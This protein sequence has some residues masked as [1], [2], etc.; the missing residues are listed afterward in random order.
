VALCADDRADL[1]RDALAS[2]FQQ[3][4]QDF[5][6]IIAADGPLTPELEAVV[7]E[8]TVKDARLRRVDIPER[9]GPAAARNRA[10]A[11]ARGTYTA[12]LDADD[13]AL[14]ERL[15]KQLQLL[16]STGVDILGTGC[17][18]YGMVSDTRRVP[19]GEAAVRRTMWMRNPLVHSTV[20][21]RTALLRE[22][23]YPE[24]LRYGEDY[25]LWVNLARQGYRIDNHPEALVRYFVNDTPKPHG[26]RWGRFTSD[27]ETRLRALRLLSPPLA[28]FFIPAA[29]LIAATRLLPDFVWRL[30][31]RMR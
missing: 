19:V 25:R 31:R 12:I 14:P 21:A 7:A 2:V 28:Q 6:C 8:C 1:F 20:M 13:A 9:S 30:L 23:P 17:D 4:M 27:A 10:V 26:G 24:N 5:E 29:V 16:E 18:V 11:Q 15:E 3:S 22:H